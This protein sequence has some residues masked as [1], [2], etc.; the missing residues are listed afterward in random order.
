MGLSARILERYAIVGGIDP[1]AYG[2]GAQNSDTIDM[3]YWRRVAFIVEAGT[4]A[5]T[6]TLDG[7]VQGSAA[8]DMSSPSTIT[9]KTITQLTEAGTDSDKYVGIEV[10]SEEVMA[11]GF[12][13]IRFVATLGAAGGDY[14]VLAIG[15]P[16][17]YSKDVT[18]NDLSVVDEIIG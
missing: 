4:L 16:A 8:S 1:D 13:Y 2:T 14:A 6:A 9:G 11:Q 18:A 3:K 7:L 15:E 10:T 5:S 12:R 17:H